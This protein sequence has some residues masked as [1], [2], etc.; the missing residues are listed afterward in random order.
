[1]RYVLNV[2]VLFI[3]CGGLSALADVVLCDGGFPVMNAVSE[4]SVSETGEEIITPIV[5]YSCQ[6]Y[7]Q[8][9]CPTS[10]VSYDVSGLFPTDMDGNCNSEKIRKVPSHGGFVA[11]GFPVTLCDNGYFD[12]VACVPYSEALENCPTGYFKAFA[13]KSV[14]RVYGEC[15]DKTVLFS[16]ENIAVWTYPY[17]DNVDA[18]I[19]LRL[20]DTGYDMNYL[21]ECAALC[22]VSNTGVKTQ[23]LRTDT[24]LSF[25]VYSKKLTV[26]SLNV[27]TGNRRCYVNMIP[28]GGLN[29]INITSEDTTYR[30]VY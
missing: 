7:S 23:Y 25:P 13:N 29:A 2:S 3:F 10:Y 24:G 16:N 18:D 21:G 17:D 22:S 4:T 30:V 5:E 28:G 11:S 20:C 8:G 12:G 9:I 19:V 14:Q 1:M 27:K 15:P 6:P 26:P